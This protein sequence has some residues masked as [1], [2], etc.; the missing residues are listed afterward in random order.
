MIVYFISFHVHISLPI[1]LPFDA[2]QSARLK[3]TLQKYINIALSSKMIF[4]VVDIALAT[5][6]QHDKTSFTL[7]DCLAQTRRHRADTL[8]R[9]INRMRCIRGNSVWLLYLCMQQLFIHLSNLDL[10]PL[11]NFDFIPLQATSNKENISGCY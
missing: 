6:I 8:L 7:K 9:F 11:A 1:I 10:Q 2:I 4:S 3:V 5:Q